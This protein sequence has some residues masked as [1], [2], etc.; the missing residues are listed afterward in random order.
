[1][2]KIN[3]KTKE[4]FDGLE[5]SNERKEEIYKKIVRSKEK[6]YNLKFLIATASC[7]FVLLL[8]IISVAYA[9][10]IKQSLN[11]LR[12]KYFQKSVDDKE[13]LM[14]DVRSDSK[15]VINY[16]AELSLDNE[17]SYD[18]LEKKL[19][20]NILDNS[21][22]KKKDFIVKNIEKKNGN[23]GFLLL[24]IDN[25]FDEHPDQ[26]TDEGNIYSHEYIKCNFE[27]SISSKYS[28]KSPG[29]VYSSSNKIEEIYISSL[30]TNAV[31]ARLG[32]NLSDTIWDVRFD[33]NNIS[34]HLELFFFTPGNHKDQLL[35]ILN[36]FNI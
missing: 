6:K 35:E 7:C 25:V 4:F 23:I 22:F 16:D 21:L 24:G 2:K 29:R 3:D 27:V 26:I 36:S 14:T 31:I 5:I 15:S 1:M 8:G 19:G 12:V 17:Y 34:Y 33:Y 10:E 11:T 20:I 9:E 13:F 28:E 30:D 18:D 32:G